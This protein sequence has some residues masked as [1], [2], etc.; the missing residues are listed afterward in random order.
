M[1]KFKLTFPLVF[2]FLL[3]ANVYA[4]TKPESADEVIKEAKTE[5]AKSNRNVFVIFH[6]SWCVW[7]H[8]MDSAMNDKS[9]KSFFDKNYVIKHLTVDERADKKILENPGAMALLTK[10]N[11]DQQGIP[12]WFILD[13]HGK[14]LADS[15][16][17][18]ESGELTGNNVGCPA[19]TGE[20]AYFIRVLK[21]T[22]PLSDQQLQLVQKRFLQIGN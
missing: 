7:C 6:A 15:R 5:A 9:I 8:R 18:S 12:Y 2:S 17:H 13:K 4:Q 10:Y 21:N 14:L 16:V 3:F 1:K 11:G 19:Q 20:V 22:S